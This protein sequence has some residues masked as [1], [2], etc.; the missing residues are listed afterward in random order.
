VLLNPS[1]QQNIDY[2]T[3]LISARM[4]QGRGEALFEI[5]IEGKNE[6]ST[7]SCKLKQA[8]LYRGWLFYAFVKRGL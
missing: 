6:Q 2:L 5:G 4:D 8:F 3:E 1:Q 7:I